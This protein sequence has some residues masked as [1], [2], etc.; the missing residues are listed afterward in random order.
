[1]AFGGARNHERALCRRRHNKESMAKWSLVANN[2]K[3]CTQVLSGM[4]LMPTDGPTDITSTNVAPIDSA[5]R[6]FSAMANRFRKAVQ[7]DSNTNKKPLHHRPNGF[8]YQMGGSKSL[9][10]QQHGFNYKIFVRKYLVPVR[11][12]NRTS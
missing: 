4:R 5:L 12:P 3:G 10:R 9:T 6:A 2:I 11:M 7:A 8:L 1:M